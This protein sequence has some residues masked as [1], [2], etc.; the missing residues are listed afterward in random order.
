MKTA[1]G[2]GAFLV[3]LAIIL[4]AACIAPVS[5]TPAPVTTLGGATIAREALT[6]NFG[7][8]HAKA[9][10]TYPAQGNPDHT[11]K[12]FPGLGHSL[13]PATRLLDDNFR[14]IAPLPRQ[15]LVEWLQAYRQ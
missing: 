14:P 11:L 15:A 2:L 3:G 6:I 10:L 1:Q 4:F 13:G 5:Q 8:F 7:N 9:E 12:I